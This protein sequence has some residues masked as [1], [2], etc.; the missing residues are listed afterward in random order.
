MSDEMDVFL[1]S[2]TTLS[3]HVITNRKFK[4]P[5]VVIHPI[6]QY[7]PHFQIKET[8]HFTSVKTR[9]RSLKSQYFKD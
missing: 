1:H 4:T 2:H 5:T 7:K 9:Y 3:F 6:L 8:T